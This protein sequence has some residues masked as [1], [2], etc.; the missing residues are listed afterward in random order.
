L[1]DW[2]FAGIET[3]D[4]AGQIEPQPLFVECYAAVRTEYGQ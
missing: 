1:T 4:Q 3:L 2:R